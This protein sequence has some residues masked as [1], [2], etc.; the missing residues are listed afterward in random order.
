MWLV[1]LKPAWEIN[2]MNKEALQNIFTKFNIVPKNFSIY[3]EALTHPSFD[4]DKKLGHNYQRLEFLGDAVISKIV[5]EHLYKK[6]PKLNEEV[7]TKDRI[8]IVQGKTQVKAAKELGFDIKGVIDIGGSVRDQIVTDK[9]L[10]DVFEAFIGAVFLDQG[11]RKVYEILK[12][13]LI[14]YY[15][16]HWLN[17]LQDFKSKLQELMQK[18][19][20]QSIKY[21]VTSHQNNEYI[22]EVW[23]NNIKYGIG[24]GDRVKDAEMQAA[25]DAYTKCIKKNK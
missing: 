14:H 7:M 11:E 6:D 9:M 13:T 19:S 23:C 16:I 22:V 8:L 17:A 1:K 25:K 18:Y 10:E 20:K 2:N 5:A 3:Q 12:R 15:E 4:N 21:K 24:K